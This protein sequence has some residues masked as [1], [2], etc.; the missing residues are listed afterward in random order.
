VAVI[1]I[2]VLSLGVH[3]AAHG[4][5]ALKC[6]DPTARD[7]GRITLNPLVHI[8]PVMTILVPVVLFLTLKFPFGAAKAVPVVFHNLRRP[9]RDM[10]LVALAGPASNIL[11]A[12]L[13]QVLLKVAQELG[14]FGPGT[15]GYETLTQGIRLNIILAVFNMI[16][17]PPLDG[18]RV[19]AWLLP[20]SLRGPY[21]RLEAFGLMLVI[22]LVFSGVID[23]PMWKTMRVVARWVSEIA[24]L[25]GMW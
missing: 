11:I 23:E 25:G 2:L 13:L 24:S 16:P 17:V 6:G 8:D 20:E 19:M 22:A 9:H 4:W 18:S 10:A 1:T 14:Y 7:L 3:E 15:V 5:V 12:I 21:V